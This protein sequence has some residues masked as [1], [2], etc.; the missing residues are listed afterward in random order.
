MNECH[1][2]TNKSNTYFMTD[3]AIIERKMI[4]LCFSEHKMRE[5]ERG[6][7]KRNKSN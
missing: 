4:I 1:T 3:F 2:R 5:R 6:N 7:R